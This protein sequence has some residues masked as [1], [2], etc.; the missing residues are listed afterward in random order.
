M[1]NIEVPFNPEP[2]T[3]RASVYFIKKLREI[4]QRRFGED[5]E[6]NAEPSRGWM[7]HRYGSYQYKNSEIILVLENLK[8]IGRIP[9][10][11]VFDVDGVVRRDATEDEW[12]SLFQ[13]DD[14]EGIFASI[15]VGVIGGPEGE[16]FA[17]LGAGAVSI[18]PGLNRAPIHNAKI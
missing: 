14:N 15:N 7:G 5:I 2:I 8:K 18:D 9:N 17:A 1:N 4:W 12:D 13:S 6:F 11:P 10:S 3:G 16:I